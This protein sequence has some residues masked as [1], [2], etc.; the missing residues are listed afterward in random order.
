MRPQQEVYKRVRVSTEVIM[1]R[2]LN[3][4]TREVETAIHVTVGAVVWDSVLV[5]ARQV[6]RTLKD[7]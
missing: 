1:E 6:S 7:G 2:T 3:A 4:V 5:L